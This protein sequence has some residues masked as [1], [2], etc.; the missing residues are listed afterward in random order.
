MCARAALLSGFTLTKQQSTLCALH[1]RTA[2]HLQLCLAVSTQRTFPSAALRTARRRCARTSTCCSICARC[3]QTSSK[4][5][6]LLKAKTSAFTLNPTTAN[7]QTNKQQQLQPNKQTTAPH[8]QTIKP[9]TN[10]L[11]RVPKRKVSPFNQTTKQTNT[12]KMLLLSLVLLGC[13]L[14]WGADAEAG[15]LSIQSADNNIQLETCVLYEPSWQSWNASWSA[16]VR[17]SSSTTHMHTSTPSKRNQNNKVADCCMLCSC[18]GMGWCVLL[19][20]PG[21]A[22]VC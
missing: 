6:F 8:K 5:I 15:K 18:L 13:G 1:L 11:A 12:T 14:M 16:L 4:L 3:T 21:A 22:C 19:L 10:N 17:R 7:K 2:S 9:S 20:S